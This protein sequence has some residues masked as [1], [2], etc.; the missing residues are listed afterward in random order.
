MNGPYEGRLELTWTNKHLNLLA[1]EDG[2]Y[3]W[4]RQSD[5]RVAEVRLL[6]DVETVGEVQVSK[7][8]AVDNLLI[9][10]D[11][12]H[13]LTSL[14]ELPEFAAVYRGK[15][16]A[17]YI[18]PPFNTQQAF[19]NYDDALEHSVWLT[20]LRDR[21]VQIKKLLSEDGSLWVHLDDSEMPYCKVVLDEVFGRE[22]FVANIIWQKLSTRENRTDVSTVHDYVLIFAKDKATWA[23]ARNP[24]PF[25]KEQLARYKNPDDDPRGP[26]QSDN[27]SGKAGPGR[28]SSQFYG[29]TLPSGRVVQ[30]PPGRCWL[31]TEDRFKELVRDNRIWFGANGDGPVRLKRFLSDVAQ[32]LVPTTLW[33]ADEVGTNTTAKKHILSMFPDTTPFATPKPEGLL[34]RILEIATNPGDLVLDCFLGSGTTS[35]VAHKMGRRWVGIESSAETLA[36]FAKPRLERVVA[37]KEQGGVT[38]S[39]AWKGGGGVRVLDVAPSM[40]TASD[41]M[42]FLADWATNTAL[43]EAT[44]AQ[45]GYEFEPDLPFCGRKGRTRLAVI[46]GLVN[47]DVVQLLVDRL[48]EK[49]RLLVCGTAVED[50]ASTFLRDSGKGSI[51]KIPAAILRYYERPSRLRSLLEVA[52]AGESDRTSPQPEVVA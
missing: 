23:A 17:A 40:F 16:R 25:G 51:R 49:E 34:Q 10:G 38:S 52:P 32:G 50:E 11:A 14:A 29:I 5:Y 42:V 2:S 26:W 47:V 27:P 41:G 9:R 6:H 45:L 15:V 28:R 24:I 39:V 8:R 19:A 33:L 36:T 4:L 7:Q 12:L 43:G 30:P 37:G 48:I 46:D 3:E 22:N 18:D 31:W 13:G 1:H 20:M 44:A 35:A 21:V